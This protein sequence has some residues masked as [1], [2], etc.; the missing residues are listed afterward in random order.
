MGERGTEDL[1]Y[2]SRFPIPYLSPLLLLFAPPLSGWSFFGN[3]LGFAGIWFFAIFV[4]LWY[5]TR[6]EFGNNGLGVFSVV[7]AERSLIPYSD[8]DGM[9]KREGFTLDPVAGLSFRRVAIIIDGKVR[10]QMSPADRDEFMDEL[11]KRIDESSDRVPSC[12]YP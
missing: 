6:Y 1:T 5:G 2:R 9:E 10:V 3:I 11:R 8:I 12:S 7:S 4:F